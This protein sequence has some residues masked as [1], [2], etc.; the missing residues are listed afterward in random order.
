VSSD[1]TPHLFYPIQESSLRFVGPI[2]ILKRILKITIKRSVYR[3]E[4]MKVFG[5][6]SEWS[7]G[8]QDIKCMFDF[9]EEKKETSFCF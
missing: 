2:P 5:E 6:Q 7:T 1:F 3:S 9:T 8:L 4:V